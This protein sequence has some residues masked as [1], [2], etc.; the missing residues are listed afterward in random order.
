MP[1][2]KVEKQV[3][4]KTKMIEYLSKEHKNEFGELSD[5]SAVNKKHVLYTVKT[6]LPF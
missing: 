5:P 4:N 3:K 6:K 2:S 1:R